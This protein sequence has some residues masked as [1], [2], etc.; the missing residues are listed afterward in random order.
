MNRKWYV[1]WYMMIGVFVILCDQITKQWALSSLYDGPMH[2]SSWLTLRL[3]FNRGISW[4]MFSSERALLFWIITAIIFVVALS[5]A[6]MAYRGF[7]KKRFILG[8]LLVVAGAASN[9]IDRF[10]HHGVIDFIELSYKGWAWPIF[11]S[12]DCSIVLGVICIFITQ[13]RN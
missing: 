8:E 2:I 9:L 5:V 6:V 4:G 1:L 3:V 13:Y 7:L 11:N 12:A 10:V